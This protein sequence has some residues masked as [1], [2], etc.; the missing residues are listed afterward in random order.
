MSGCPGTN[1][2]TLALYTTTYE[3]IYQASGIHRPFLS[4][5]SV[6]SGQK[7]GAPLVSRVSR[8]RQDVCQQTAV[9]GVLVESRGGAG[10]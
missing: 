4:L 1:R 7:D 5:V 10:W 3:S 8:I 9:S 6:P 2:P